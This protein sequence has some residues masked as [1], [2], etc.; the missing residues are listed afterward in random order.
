MKTM[1]ENIIGKFVIELDENDRKLLKRFA[2]AVE[3]M[4]PTTIDWD[5]PKVRAVGVDE[6]GNIKW[7]PAGENNERP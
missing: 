4:Q 6:L 5:E 7:G 2:N 3:L 1:A